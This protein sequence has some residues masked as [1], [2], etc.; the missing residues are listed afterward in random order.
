[1]QIQILCPVYNIIPQLECALN[2][3]P[4]SAVKIANDVCKSSQTMFEYSIN[5]NNA[6]LI[7][8]FQ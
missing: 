5:V 2:L 1:M 3:N 6:T 8:L 7:A 4:K